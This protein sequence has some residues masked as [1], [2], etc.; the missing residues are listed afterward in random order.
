M[1]KKAPSAPIVVS[2]PDA[3]RLAAITSLARMGEQLAKALNVG[4]AVNITSCEFHDVK[5]GVEVRGK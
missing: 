4:P 5:T 1:K 3:D 2:L